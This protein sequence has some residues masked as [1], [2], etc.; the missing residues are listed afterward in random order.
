M[1]ETRSTTLTDEPKPPSSPARSALWAFIWCALAVGVAGN[2]AIA[3]WLFM[4][5]YPQ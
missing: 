2:M 5:N 4:G 3:V 1:T